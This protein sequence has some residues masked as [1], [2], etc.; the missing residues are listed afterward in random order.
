MYLTYYCE[1]CNDYHQGERGVCL[2]CGKGNRI[3]GFNINPD[4]TKRILS[5]YPTE[6]EF[7]R[8]CLLTGT[9][10]LGIKW[11][12]EEVMRVFYRRCKELSLK[13]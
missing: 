6:D 8:R 12:N 4:K 5:S 2:K 9:G 1:E 11:T 10:P 7:V 3:P 13:S